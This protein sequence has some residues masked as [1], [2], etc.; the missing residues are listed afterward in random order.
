MVYPI[1]RLYGRM[2]GLVGAHPAVEVVDDALEDQ[3]SAEYH[4]TGYQRIIFVLDDDLPVRVDLTAVPEAELG[5]EPHGLILLT[6]E[7][8]EELSGNLIVRRM[9]TMHE[10]Q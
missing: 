8:V 1:D 6:D 4:E 5:E 7:V 2:Q 3:D 10:V 9:D